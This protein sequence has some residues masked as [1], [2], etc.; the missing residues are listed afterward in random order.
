M[1]FSKIIHP[2]INILFAFPSSDVHYNVPYVYVNSN[3]FFWILYDY[4]LEVL[5][6]HKY[7]FICMLSMSFLKL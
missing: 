7:T 4:F 1:T 6:V 2:E 5:Y 3:I